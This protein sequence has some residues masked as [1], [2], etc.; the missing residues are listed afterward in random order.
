MSTTETADLIESVNDLTDTVIGKVEE[1]DT[2]IEVK[3]KQVDEFIS[4]ARAEYPLAPNVISDTKHFNAMCKDVE[5]GTP[6]D[7]F[8][9]H[10]YP[11]SISSAV[12][13]VS[14]TVTK[15]GVHDLADYDLTPNGDLLKAIGNK[16]YN[17]QL[18]YGSDFKTLLFD[19]E[20]TQAMSDGREYI[21]VLSNSDRFT[22][23]SRG[24][25]ITQSS[26]FVKV[27]EHEGDIQFYP[28]LNMAGTINAGTT[29][30]EEWQYLHATRV[31]WGGYH[32]PRFTGVGKM[33]VALCL[34]Y[35][36]T[37]NHGGKFIWA[38]SVGHKYTHTAPSVLNELIVN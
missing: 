16:N 2:R 18:Y 10:T 37:G 36:G 32:Q 22:G 27:L 8:D 3:E 15:L 19:V 25:F 4:N 33:K 24:E 28:S 13:A 12:A 38:D 11:W 26:C 9:S 5:L 31:G 14:G 35:I 21:I 6:V 30:N 23:W 34:P 20:I 1:I 7:I 17:G 29:I